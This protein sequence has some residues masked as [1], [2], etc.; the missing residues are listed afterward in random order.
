MSAPSYRKRPMPALRLPVQWEFAP[1]QESCRLFFR[2]DKTTHC[3]RQ[4]VPSSL[5]HSAPVSV[6]SWN[7]L[8][9]PFEPE[10]L[11]LGVATLA[12]GVAASIRTGLPV[13][14]GFTCFQLLP[15]LRLRKTLPAL[16]SVRIRFPSDTEAA[17]G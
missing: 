9:G 10:T 3:W 7:T 13:H 5:V 17:T 6:V 11:L 16:S 8:W 1:R 12:S 2:G 15:E 14:C 4:W